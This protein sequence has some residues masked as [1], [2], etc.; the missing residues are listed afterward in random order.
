MVNISQTAVVLTILNMPSGAEKLGCRAKIKA[1]SSSWPPESATCCGDLET[2]EGEEI[3][4][5]TE[6][7]QKVT[8]TGKCKWRLRFHWALQVQD[9]NSVILHRNQKNIYMAIYILIYIYLHIYIYADILQIFH[10][11]TVL[12][13]LNSLQDLSPLTMDRTQARVPQQA[14]KSKSLDRQEIPQKIKT[15]WLQDFGPWSLPGLR[16]SE[17]TVSQ[18]PLIEEKEE[19]I[20][21][22]NSRARLCP[23]WFQAEGV[24]LGRRVYSC[25]CSLLLGITKGTCT[26]FP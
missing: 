6:G 20:P 16:K 25:T 23:G 1:R 10:S 12:A 21:P 26:V 8:E 22:G 17:V 11:C 15:F 9:L 4:G 2:D 24:A 5:A 3:L 14:A 7:R 13:V 19:D 18:G